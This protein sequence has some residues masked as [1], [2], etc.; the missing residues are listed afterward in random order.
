MLAMLAAPLLAA[1]VSIG[2]GASDP[3]HA[4]FALHDPGLAATPAR[5]QPPLVP[6]LLIQ[7]VP[8][9]AA[10]DTAS[11]AYSRRAGEYAFYQLAS[12]DERPLRALP[13]L[14]QRRLETR[15]L[16]GAVGLLGDPMRADWLL[17]LGVEALH[18]DV[19]VSPGVA[20][21][22]LVAELYDRR[23]QVRVA[24]RHFEAAAPA[25]GAG[26]GAGAAALSAATAQAFDA[27]VPWL[28]GELQRVRP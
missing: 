8:A 2:A 7:P 14:L 27:I 20:R 9:G 17:T 15:A 19:D 1:C 12:W 22:G 23:A 13:R 28:E 18:H 10:A 25:A 11:I 6:A 5:A 24:R 3:P 16:A 26:P 21:V 4:H